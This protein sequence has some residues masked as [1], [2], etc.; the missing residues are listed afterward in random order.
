M[1]I[2]DPEEEGGDTIM[3][4]DE[5]ELEDIDLDKLEESLNRK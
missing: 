2:K 4:I 1:P 3:Q 5:R